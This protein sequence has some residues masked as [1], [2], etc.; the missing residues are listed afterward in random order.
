LA[1]KETVE[2]A[3]RA[4]AGD[5]AAFEKLCS[6]KV[7]SVTVNA[8]GSLGNVHDAEEVAQ[9]TFVSMYRSIGQLKNPEAIDIWILR[10]VQNKC[11][12]FLEKKNPVG[13]DVDIDDEAL[14]VEEEYGEFIPEKYAENEEFSGILFDIVMSLPEKRREAIFLHYYEDRSYKEIAAISGVSINTVATNIM[15]ARTMIKTALGDVENQKLAG[16]G[17]IAAPVGTT[18]SASVLSRV[19]KEQAQLRI[20]PDVENAVR[21]NFLRAFKVMHQKAVAATVAKVAAG[22]A[23]TAG[24]AF[25]VVPSVIPGSADMPPPVVQTIPEEYPSAGLIAFTGGAGADGHLN[26]QG[27]QLQGEDFEISKSEWEIIDASGK[28]V[29]GGNGLDPSI[30]LQELSQ[31]AQIGRYTLKYRL[32]DADGHVIIKERDFEITSDSG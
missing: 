27:A 5:R 23:V 4:T 11:K 13:S 20:T 21:E 18:S 7:R 17:V 30:A 6:E 9:E 32:T 26:P 25:V 31:N 24:A 2:L 22:V 28:S 8:Y 14:A 29:W 19:L 10:I 3:R 15:R 1:S 12:R 16:L